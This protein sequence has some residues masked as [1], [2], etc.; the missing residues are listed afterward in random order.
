MKPA[1]LAILWSYQKCKVAW[2]RSGEWTTYYP[3]SRIR[4]RNQETEARNNHMRLYITTFVL[5]IFAGIA[6]VG[7]SFRRQLKYIRQ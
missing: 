7:L 5:T 1:I 2:K 6:I 4:N 3:G